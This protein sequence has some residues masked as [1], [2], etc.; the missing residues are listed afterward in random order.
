MNSNNNEISKDTQE[1]FKN[2]LQACMNIT[3]D[4]KEKALDVRKNDF[5]E[6]IKTHINKCEN[7]DTLDKI[8]NTLTNDFAALHRNDKKRA[9]A[10]RISI[11]NTVFKESLSEAKKAKRDK[12]IIQKIKDDI[13]ETFNNLYK[14]IEEIL[15]SE[16]NKRKAELREVINE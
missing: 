15:E 16:Y 8:K 1:D 7:L 3:L 4:L 6:Q 12:E 10:Q 9:E 13:E 11:L 2:K 5:I 14:E